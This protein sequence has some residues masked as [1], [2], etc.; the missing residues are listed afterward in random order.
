MGK[1]REKMINA[2]NWWGKEYAI[3]IKVLKIGC[4]G[5]D[6]KVV[7]S[8]PCRHLREEWSRKRGW[9]CLMSKKAPRF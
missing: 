2:G 9:K 5:K 1:I 3:V 4:V 7:K 8:K 6:L